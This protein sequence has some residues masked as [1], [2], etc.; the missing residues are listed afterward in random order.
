LAYVH[1]GKAYPY[2]SVHERYGEFV[3]LIARGDEIYDIMTVMRVYI[4]MKLLPRVRDVISAV[5]VVRYLR[6][7]E[8]L[9][10]YVKFS[11][12]RTAVKAFKALYGLR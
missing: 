4:I 6:D 1:N 5:D 7:F 8:V 3:R 9:F 10:W 12:T 11:Q 2:V